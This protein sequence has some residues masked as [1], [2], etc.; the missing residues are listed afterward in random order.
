[1]T[2]PHPWPN[3]RWPASNPTSR[4]RLNGS[5]RAAEGLAAL[6]LQ[7]IGAYSGVRTSHYAYVEWAT[8]ERELYDLR[9]DPGELDNI[10]AR[11]PVGLLQA[12]HARLESMRTCRADTCRSAEDSPHLGEHDSFG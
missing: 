5:L 6:L 8:G 9:T 3:S 11:A 1:V 4:T 7:F 10:A 12:L 2:A